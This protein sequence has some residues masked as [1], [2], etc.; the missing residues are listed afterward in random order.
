MGWVGT[1][2]RICQ[3]APHP[4]VPVPPL[5]SVT[6]L[7]HGCFADPGFAP[8]PGHGKLLAGLCSSPCSYD[9]FRES[10]A[11]KARLT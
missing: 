7:D 10:L 6:A 8:R 9:S 5:P 4:S 3:G 2:D 11:S 1:W